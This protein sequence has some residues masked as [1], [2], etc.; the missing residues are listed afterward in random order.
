MSNNGRFLLIVMLIFIIFSMTGCGTKR[1]ETTSTTEG[2]DSLKERTGQTGTSSK[3]DWN[4]YLSEEKYN[5]DVLDV[6]T[7]NEYESI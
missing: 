5:R 7:P 6:K 2:I 4:T 1:D 3:L